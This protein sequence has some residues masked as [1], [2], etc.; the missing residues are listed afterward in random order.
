[1][2]ITVEHTD[3]E[4]NEVILRCRELD[5]EMLRL[6]ALVR[7]VETE[8]VPL[9]ACGGRVLAADVCAAEDV[10]SFDRSA[11]DG[12]A[13]RSADAG[14]ASETNPV[15]LRIVEEIRA[16]DTPSCAVTA[17]TAA[18]ILTG[19]PLPPGADAV[20]KYEDTEFSEDRVTLFSPAKP[21]SN[22]VFWHTGGATALFAEKQILG[23]LY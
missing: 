16:G 23:R 19:A 10:P 20:C 21:G 11:F 14:A 8:R 18:K 17:G 15:T 13:F 7:P 4:E 22:V 9:A 5:D 1:M 2:K 12:Y 3:S 6:L